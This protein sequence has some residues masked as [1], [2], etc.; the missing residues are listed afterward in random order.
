MFNKIL[1]YLSKFFK[2]KP[3]DHTFAD[4]V[5]SKCTSDID[6]NLQL[7]GVMFKIMRDFKYYCW[8]DKDLTLDLNGL[9]T[10]Y[11]GGQSDNRIT[12]IH[13]TPDGVV[14]DCI[15]KNESRFYIYVTDRVISLELDAN[16]RA[17]LGIELSEIIS[18]PALGFL[19]YFTNL[20]ENY[21]DKKKKIYG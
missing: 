9:E 4:A 17:L 12:I 18:D 20:L 10:L 14:Y 13:E 19:E 2:K 21:Y 15:H 3:L 16:Y 1:S 7:C 8:I 11:I 5:L 6:R